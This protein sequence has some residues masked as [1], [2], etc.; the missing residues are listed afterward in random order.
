MISKELLQKMTNAFVMY[1]ISVHG[2]NPR[3]KLEGTTLRITRNEGYKFDVIDVWNKYLETVKKGQ[4]TYVDA[5][6]QA[7]PGVNLVHY[8]QKNNIKDKLDAQGSEAFEN[9]LRDLFEEDED[10]LSFEEIVGAIGRN[11]DVIGFL[12]FLKNP[13]K[14]MPIR[15][16]MFES[17]LRLLG[18]EAHLSHNCTWESYQQYNGWV[19]EIYQ[20]LRNNLNNDIQPID[21]HSFLW[22]APGLINYMDS[23]TQ[24]VEHKK[25]GKGIVIG[26]ERDLIKIKFGKV[27]KSFDKQDCFDRGLLQIIP[28]DI[29]IYNDDANEE[30]PASEQRPDTQSPSAP[31]P[32]NHVP[33]LDSE[34]IA[35]N[36]E[37]DEQLIHALAIDKDEKEADIPEN[38]YTRI[39]KPRPEAIVINGRKVYPRK[40]SVAAEA[41]A[42]SGYKCEICAD[43]PTFVRRNNGK[44]YMEPH[45]LVPMSYQDHFDNSLDRKENIVSL[46]SNCHN[47]IHYG[48]DAAKLVETLYSV[49]K[50]L[51]E[52]VGIIVSLSELQQ[53]Y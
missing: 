53:M 24:V 33:Y 46:C 8:R 48:K 43:H 25:F 4:L 42:L 27:I 37:M 6:L 39:A 3:E 16:D 22:I 32:E 35:V 11:Y 20:F 10:P 9:A 47:E 31:K 2:I 21:A 45:H 28:T 49:R 14:Y 34:T 30:T 15:S 23:D 50:D 5:V 41:I 12:F 52:S 19:R 29:N 44:P 36:E 7:L 18:I 38:H 26:Y 13:N 1:E 51:L 17:R 40:A